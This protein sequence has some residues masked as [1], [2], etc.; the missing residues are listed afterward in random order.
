MPESRAAGTAMDDEDPGL[1][2][3]ERLCYTSGV[4][5]KSQTVCKPG[6]VRLAT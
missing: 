4:K 1:R 2:R 5:N 6:S 3:D